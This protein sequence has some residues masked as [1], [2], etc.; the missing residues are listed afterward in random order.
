MPDLA[1]IISKSAS[2]RVADEYG[3]WSG[4]GH[5]MSSTSRPQS[6]AAKR[7]DRAKFGKGWCRLKGLVHYVVT[8]RDDEEVRVFLQ[9]DLANTRKKKS[10]HRVL[11]WQNSEQKT[12]NLSKIFS[13]LLFTVT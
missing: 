8:W 5:W 13:S 2:E 7:Y 9:I 6:V 12:Q 10:C 1:E 3:W 4:S 11:L